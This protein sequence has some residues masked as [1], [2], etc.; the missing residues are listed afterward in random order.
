[1][2]IIPLARSILHVKES[3]LFRNTLI[4]LAVLAITTII[5]VLTGAIVARRVGVQQVGM[6]AVGAMLV[7]FVSILEN[8]T[9]PAHI[10]EVAGSKDFKE[11]ITTHL[12]L[13]F[14]FASCGAVVILLFADY[15]AAAFQCD[16]RIIQIYAFIPFFSSISSAIHNTFEAKQLMVHR[17][18]IDVV[19]TTSYFVFACLFVYS[20]IE[21]AFLRVIAMA[22]TLACS[23]ILLNLKLSGFG[24]FN[25]GIAR[26]Y[27]SFGSKTILSGLF[28][29]L[30]FWADAAMISLF[31]G[32]Y[33]TGVYRTAYNL[34]FY[35]IVA[36]GAV[37]A[38]LYPS[39]CESFHLKNR[40]KFREAHLNGFV[41]V[42]I[43]ILPL[44]LLFTVFSS[45][46]V[47]L[48]YGAAFADAAL[49]LSI[50]SFSVFICCLSNVS[51]YALLAAG[52]AKLLMV[53][54]GIGALLN[55]IGNY[56]LIGIY[57]LM[58]AIM[59]TFITFIFLM[60][61]YSFL[62]YR[63]FYKS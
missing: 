20:G 57:G 14:T 38:A 36:L 30:I 24:R 60:V 4:V 49:P 63:K 22:L 39:L 27:V 17:G 15:L 28:S 8:L 44:T 62:A 16:V 1:M 26:A 47:L 51:T 5:G 48:L 50:L 54:D 21:A 41:L 29:K 31:L 61:V 19:N 33:S 45:Q 11:N 10:R 12:V 9:A 43:F 6:L 37:G 25:R 35:Q 46:I 58:G 56:V 18:V 55:I 52:Y 32:T 2:K 34:A 53:I 23:L 3:E 13:K 42:I 7:E 59:S 40:E